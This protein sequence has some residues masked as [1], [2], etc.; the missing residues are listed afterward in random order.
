MAFHRATLKRQT[1]HHT[2]VLGFVPGNLNRLED[3]RHGAPIQ[4][5]LDGQY[6]H[7]HRPHHP[8]APAAFIP[9]PVPD[10]ALKELK[11]HGLTEFRVGPEVYVIAVMG[12]SPAKAALAV[13]AVLGPDVRFVAA[14]PPVPD[15]PAEAEAE[16]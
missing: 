13:Q 11:K 3:R 15:D 16:A 10:D 4:F 2:V 9:V 6:Y 7:V 12:T 5:Y 1:P 8:P 14:L